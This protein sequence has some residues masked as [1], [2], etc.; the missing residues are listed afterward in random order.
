[1]GEETK[2]AP[3]KKDGKGGGRY[4]NAH[5]IDLG[6]VEANFLMMAS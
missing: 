2:W 6:L 3:I 4:K 5:P 1:M